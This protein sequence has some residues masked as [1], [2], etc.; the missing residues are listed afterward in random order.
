MATSTEPSQGIQMVES[1]SHADETKLPGTTTVNDPDFKEDSDSDA[2]KQDG[3][4][5]MEAIT[6][7]WTKRAMWTTFGL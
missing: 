4:K 1:G 2:G 3:V 5:Q 6:S 7:A